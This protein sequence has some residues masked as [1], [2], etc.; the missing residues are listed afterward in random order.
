MFSENDLRELVNYSAKSAML[1]IYLNTDPTLGNSDSYRL[2]LRNMLKSVELEEDVERVEQYFNNEYDWAGKSV[3]IFSDVSAE[4]L[5]VYP[6]AVPVA[7]L[8]NI[9]V[10]PNVKPLASLLDSYGGYGVVLLD[11]QGARMFYFHL[12]ELKEQEGI[13]GDSVKQ[14]KGGG[15]A[16]TGMRG[17]VATQNR[18]IEETVERN[19]RES[20]EFATYFFQDKHIRRILLSGSDDNIALFR[21]YLPKSWQSLI[22]GT[23][24]VGMNATEHE[25]LVRAMEIGQATEIAREKDLVQRLITTFAKKGAA[26]IGLEPT[27]KAVS[28][29]RVQTLVILHGYQKEGYRCPDC[30]IITS[31][32][33]VICEGCM[34]PKQ[35]VQDIVALAVSVVM[36]NHGE[37]E[38]VHQSTDLQNVGNI[39]AFLRY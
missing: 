7:D 34:Q 10:R 1:S 17:G 37:I 25:V 19:M 18:S 33:D 13:F 22:V 9:G 8:I 35:V 15:S 21:S 23:F 11:K 12:G 14:S 30:G 20:V 39:G 5:R 38:F 24:S 3:A 4:F 32:P 36:E 2:R 6:L 28:E 26:E 31:F 16:M 29:G 27:L